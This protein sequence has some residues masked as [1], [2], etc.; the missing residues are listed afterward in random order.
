MLKSKSFLLAVQSK[1]PE[2]RPLTSVARFNGSLTSSMPL[3]RS[4]CESSMAPPGDHAV[5]IA[6]ISQVHREGD[7]VI[8][9]RRGAAQ[10]VSGARPDCGEVQAQ[11]RAPHGG[12]R[13]G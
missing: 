2:K 1:W 12:E 11:L 3:V 13:R 10:P 9:R 6:A 4:I 7:G 8:P 5:D